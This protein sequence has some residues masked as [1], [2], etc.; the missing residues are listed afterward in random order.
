[1]K[2]TKL[3]L[4]T[5][6]LVLLAGCAGQT[7]V[8]DD[9]VSKVVGR[10]FLSTKVTENG[11]DRPLVAGTRLTLR[12]VSASRLIANAGCNSIS[13]DTDLSGG[14]IN[15]PDRAATAMGCPQKGVYEQ[16]SW[17]SKV[18][19]DRPT[20]K[21]DGD[22]L[23]VSTATAR[24]ELTDRRTVDP[25]RPLA[26]TRWTVDTVISGTV[27]SSATTGS[28][29]HLSFA[30]GRVTGSTGCNSLGGPATIS[31]QTISFGDGPITT[32]MACAGDGVMKLEAGVL[33][34]L[35]GDVTYKIEAGRLT[36]THPGGAGLQ[37]VADPAASPSR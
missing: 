9:N 12:F 16:D 1:M 32:K 29:A 25:D 27:A 20:W 28:R 24:I 30:G 36:L 34:T 37:L 33:A 3:L 35:R 22:T 6:A 23:V 11:K 17:L 26:G 18:L 31:G 19:G 7:M 8:A 10:T 4:G 13:G 2:G 15:M 14:R 5:F 21:L